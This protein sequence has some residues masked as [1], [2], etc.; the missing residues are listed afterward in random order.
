[1][2]FRFLVLSMTILVS[3]QQEKIIHPEEVFEFKKPNGFPETTYTFD[4][5]PV[6][7]AGFELGKK[8]FNDPKLSSDNSVACSNCHVKA[9]AFADPQHRLSVGVHDRVGIRNTP[10]IANM[11]FMQEF[12]WDGGVVHLDFVPPNAIENEL[13]MDDKLANV[14]HKLNNAPDYPE[15]FR[16]AFGDIDSITAPLMLHAF[17]QYMSMLISDNSK[18]DQYLKNEITLTAQ[19][20]NGQRLFEQKCMAC[21][22]GILFTDQD[23]HNNGLD[24]AF[25]DLGRARISE[26]DGDNGKFK[27]PSLRNVGLTA[28]YMHDGRF[29]TLEEVLDHYSE[30]VKV[31]TTLDPILS[32]NNQ[33]GIK[34]TEEEQAQII[35]FLHTLT[36]YTLISNEF[37]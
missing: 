7:K 29:E 26:W 31:S 33:I 19:E 28:P 18:Y 14:V 15:L 30:G 25:T 36:D 37:F 10:S 32:K 34:M 20:L 24:T 13:E 22:T 2:K 11:A 12:F 4:N 23:Y 16:A 1:M 6:S 35:A 9:V 27:T 8:L 17:S 3:C 21:H 5:N